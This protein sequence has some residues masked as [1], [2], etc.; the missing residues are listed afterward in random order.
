MTVSGFCQ[1]VCLSVCMQ[2]VWW[3]NVVHLP[4]KD[5][6]PTGWWLF[7]GFVCLSV[8]LRAMW[9]ANVVHLP[10]LDPTGWWPSQ[11]VCLSVCVRAVW[12]AEGEVPPQS[13]QRCGHHAG[14]AGSLQTGRP[15]PHTTGKQLKRFAEHTSSGSGDFALCAQHASIEE[16][17]NNC[18]WGWQNRTDL[19]KCT[20]QCDETQGNNSAQALLTK[21]QTR[22]SWCKC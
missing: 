1:S 7:Q 15:G 9:W 11:A 12:R 5:L 2:A 13:Q 14:S 6:N 17:V 16:W 4:A 8:C 21:G 19:G 22:R 20:R 18:W 10:R 3:A